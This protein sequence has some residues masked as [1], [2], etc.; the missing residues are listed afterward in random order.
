MG[1][2]TGA[3]KAV[4]GFLGGSGGGVVAEVVDDLHYSGEEKSKDDMQALSDARKPLSP[5]HDTWFDALIDGYNRLPR[6]AF[7]TWGFGELVGWWNVDITKMDAEK[8]SLI[9]IIVTFYF[10]GRALL[11]D[12]PKVIKSLRSIGK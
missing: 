12:M 3:L 9:I 8:M 1:W 4:G 5:S 11:K 10:A 7:A 2:I 6:P